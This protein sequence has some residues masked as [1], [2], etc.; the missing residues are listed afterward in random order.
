MFGFLAPQKRIP[1][2]R[3][4]YARICQHQRSLFGLTALP[5]LSYEATFLYQLAIDF[6]LLP[7]VAETSPECC[8]LRRL[9]KDDSQSDKTSATFAAAFG[10]LLAGVK[11]NDDLQDSGRWYNRLARWKYRKQIQHANDLIENLA[12]G[13]LQ[14]IENAV[15]A[16]SIL[17]SSAPV[18]MQEYS[19]P[20]AEGFAAVFRGFA[21]LEQHNAAAELVETFADA[22]EHI[23]RAIIAW[24]C[25]VDFEKDR[26][27]GH[28]NPLRDE[29]D[30]QNS[31]DVSLLELARLGWR[32]PEQ[33]ACS[34][35]IAS[36]T[37][38]IRPQRK[39]PVRQQPARLLERWGLVRERGYAYA[40]CDGCE[41]LCAG[42]E[43]LECLGGAGETM[44]CCGP[45]SC[46]GILCCADARDC[47][48]NASQTP[49]ES[50]AEVADA[51]PYERYHGK[52]G[53]TS[54]DLNP[55][56]YV[57]I[58]EERIPAKTAS[59]T[60][61]PDNTSIRVLRTDPFGVTVVPL[62]EP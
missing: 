38:R 22:G 48:S 28:Y 30:V 26:I 6:G 40:R 36:V 8:R 13:T 54:G 9:P 17:E 59:A 46:D 56:G 21:Q 53:I 43:C 61:L 27:R 24:D 12:P 11:L 35:V 1:K 51:G 50:K 34:N 3:R 20:T 25:A 52:E 5:F 32:L 58:D 41:I 18:P 37:A 2:W 15:Q 44:A 39:R 7:A 62:D 33:S 45:G 55:A 16:H 4:S 14:Q 49:N 60:Y 10:M 57:L 47:T 19:S 23:G 31:F 42:V 29:A